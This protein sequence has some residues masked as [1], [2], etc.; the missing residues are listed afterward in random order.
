LRK[1]K[2]A[3]ENEKKK[4]TKDVEYWAKSLREEEKV[5]TEKYCA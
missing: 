4:K 1:E 3:F 5:A 2:E